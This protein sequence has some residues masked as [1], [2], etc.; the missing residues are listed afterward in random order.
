[1]PEIEK[2]DLPKKSAF[3]FMSESLRADV[4]LPVERA[5]SKAGLYALSPD[6]GQ[7]AFSPDD[8]IKAVSNRHYSNQNNPGF[9]KKA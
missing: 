9:L 1:M 4:F 3:L 7:Y 2:A 8:I 6:N 5:S